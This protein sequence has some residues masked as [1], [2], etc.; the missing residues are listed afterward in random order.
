VPLHTAASRSL[1]RV[2]AATTTS[3]DL[4][5]LPCASHLCTP[6]R[7]NTNKADRLRLKHYLVETSFIAYV[8]KDFDGDGGGSGASRQN[9]GLE[10]KYRKNQ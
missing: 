4:A 10:E 9:R 1:Q 7:R 8:G 3:D 5:G 2:H 6:D